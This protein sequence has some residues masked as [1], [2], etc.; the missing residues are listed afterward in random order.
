MN[1]KLKKALFELGIFIIIEFMCLNLYFI[2]SG[3]TGEFKWPIEML[4][5]S[6]AGFVIQ[7][8]T[9]ISLI[10]GMIIFTYLII[11]II[12]LIKNL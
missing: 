1:E 11:V 6:F 8:I 4:T 3:I 9:L 7:A 10:C 5:S 12:L 2:I